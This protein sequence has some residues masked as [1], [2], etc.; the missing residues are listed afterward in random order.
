MEDSELTKSEIHYH[1]RW[2]DSAIDWKA[3]A[4][5][6]EAIEHAG[7]I[8]KANET[9]ITIERGDECERCNM[10]KSKANQFADFGHFELNRDFS[11]TTFPRCESYWQ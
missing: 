10:F 1:I 8:K 7:R 5:K 4:S 6:D 9:Y 2:S 3:F 11:S